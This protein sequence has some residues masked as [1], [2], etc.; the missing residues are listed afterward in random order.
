M[1]TSK[2]K[3]NRK[4]WEQPKTTG[5]QSNNRLGFNKLTNG[6]SHIEWC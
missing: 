2:Q 1:P 4:R 3:M 5:K 6:K